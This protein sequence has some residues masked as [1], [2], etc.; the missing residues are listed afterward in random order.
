MRVLDCS[1]P[2]PAR[3][4]ALDEALL[5]S[6]ERNAAPDTLRFWESAVPFV[7]IGTAQA[8]HEEVYEDR[9]RADGIAIL[10][11]C[12]AG[13]CVL[14]GPGCLNFALALRTE[15]R[16]EIASLHPSYDF[17]LGAIIRA[18]ARR[19][20][21][22]ETA[23]ISD[24]VLHGRKVSGNAQRRRRRAILHHGT[25]LY[26]ADTARMDRFLKEPLARP[27]YRGRRTHAQF[28]TALPLPPATLHAA[29]CEAFGAAP[30]IEEPLPSEM[31]ECRELACSKYESTAWTYRR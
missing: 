26:R 2:S 6:V 8:L 4:L 12:S 23:G 3:N 13:G 16:P 14:Q 17:I 21:H 31:D 24:L 7:V 29:V 5:N 30:A 10:R 9:C 11:R 25:L 19:G 22:L 28:V 15:S 1:L 27:A 20:I 18:F